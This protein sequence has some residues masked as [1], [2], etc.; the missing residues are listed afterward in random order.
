M[1]LADANK[2]IRPKRRYKRD[3]MFNLSKKKR[4][5]SFKILKRQEKR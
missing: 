4:R 3:T 5:Q 1:H 2:P